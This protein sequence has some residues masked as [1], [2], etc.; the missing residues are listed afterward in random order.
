MLRDRASLSKLTLMLSR[1]LATQTRRRWSAC[2]GLA[3]ITLIT[4]IVV[5]IGTGPCEPEYRGAGLSQWLDGTMARKG[6]SGRE[7]REVLD[8]VGPEAVPWLIQLLERRESIFDKGY[9]RLYHKWSAP[10]WLPEPRLPKRRTAR[11]NALYPLSRLAPGRKL[12][13]KAVS[14]LLSV[15]HNDDSNFKKQMFRCLGSFTNASER[16]VPMLLTGVTNYTTFEASL[17]ALQRFGT[18]AAPSLYRMA[19]EES[20]HI[21][22][23]ELA[24]E[25]IDATLYLKLLDE[26]AKRARR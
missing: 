7:M 6:V 14:V 25:K 10:R 4:V 21:R 15:E 3:A 11:F 22:P 16:V 13:D 18:A 12:E 2:I 24:L 20:G 17:E 26:K 19:R 5:C 23:A 9:L 1:P 8:S